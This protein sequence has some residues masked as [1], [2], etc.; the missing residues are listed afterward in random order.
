MFGRDLE[1]PKRVS[2]EMTSTRNG[3]PFGMAAEQPPK[4]PLAHPP[5]APEA[6]KALLPNYSGA[7][8]PA[9]PKSPFPQGDARSA[10]E[11]LHVHNVRQTR[12]PETTHRI[13]VFEKQGDPET[14]LGEIG[15]AHV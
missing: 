7:F 3:L 1:G 2:I 5:R 12:G 9:I 14:S 10:F 15:R 4:A 13:N 6:H 11:I 8:G